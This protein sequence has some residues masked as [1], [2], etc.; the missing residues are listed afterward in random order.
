MNLK[1]K[2]KLNFFLIIF[3]KKNEKCYLFHFFFELT[4]TTFL[5]TVLFE[6]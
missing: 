3:L 4:L 2:Q 6:F 5:V 1:N